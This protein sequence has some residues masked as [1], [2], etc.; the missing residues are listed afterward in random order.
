MDFND[1][2]PK[3]VKAKR[4]VRVSTSEPGKARRTF[5][6]VD[7]A[8]TFIAKKNAA[9]VDCSLQTYFLD[10]KPNTDHPAKGV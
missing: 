9:G 8:H 1:R 5:V 6:T 7:E 10:G 2:R 3:P 4:L